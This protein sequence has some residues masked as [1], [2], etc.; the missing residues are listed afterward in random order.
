MRK[1]MF[2]RKTIINER[3]DQSCSKPRCYVHV[4]LLTVIM[5]ITVS[6]GGRL[7][8]V[9]TSTALAGTYAFNDAASEAYWYSRYNLGHLVMMSGMGIQFMPPKEKVMKM[10]E[11]AGIKAGPK[12][13]YLVKAAYSSGDPH[14]TSKFN[15][16]PN[17]FL[18][19]R[20]DQAKIDKTVTPQAMGYTMI[21]EIIW[22]KSFASDVEGPDPMNHFRALVLSTEAAIQAGFMMENLKTENGLFRHAW[23]EGKVSDSSFTPQDQLV[24][25]WALSELA[26]YSSGKYKWYAAPLDHQTALKMADGL[27][28]SLEEYVKINPRFIYPD[29]PTHD[30]GLALAALS[31]YAAITEKKDLRNLTLERLIPLHAQNLIN[32]MAD[33]GKLQTEREFTQLATQA[34]AVNGLVLAYKVTGKQRYQD[35]TLRAWDYMQT[36][37]NEKA[38]LYATREGAS[39]YTYTT[40]DVG[41]VVGAFNAVIHGLD[42]DVR[43]RFTIFFDKAVNKSGL[44]IAEGPPTGGQEDGDGVPAPP[45]AGGEF[46][47]APVFATEAVY[48]VDSGQWLLTNSRF[49]T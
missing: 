5:L 44:Q 15:D 48:D 26:S 17:D 3:K 13:A 34:R 14:F 45:M 20:W 2:S 27:L 1:K 10:M 46:G 42:K 31:S 21:K 28:S 24:M 40:E 8:P 32:R 49:S 37:W 7:L 38:G 41:D 6:F 43:S 33:D 36:L 18:N 9:F 22:S 25:L 4:G 16:D 11:M 47:Q 23:K 29:L 12:N 35:A 39:R 19:F 30:I